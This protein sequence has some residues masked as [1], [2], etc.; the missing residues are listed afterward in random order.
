[1]IIKEDVGKEV[2]IYVSIYINITIEVGRE[3]I[4]IIE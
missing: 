1:M 2:C 4:E 3:R